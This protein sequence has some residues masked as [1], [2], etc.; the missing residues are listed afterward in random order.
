MRRL[1]VDEKVEVWRR[2]EYDVDD[3]VTDAEF[4][5][6]L[7]EL[8]KTGEAFEIED[9]EGV[10]YRGGEYLEDTEEAYSGYGAHMEV[11]DDDF[12]SLD[13]W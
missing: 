6:K 5:D 2:T 1:I 8:S 13:S 3:K 7:R 11:F 4:I 12:N 9:E 10:T